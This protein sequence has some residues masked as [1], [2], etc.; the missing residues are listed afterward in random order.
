MRSASLVIALLSALA[1]IT[2]AACSEQPPT[3][4]PD[5]PATV[6]SAIEQS[7][8]TTT[9][10]YTPVPTVT[11]TFQQW[12]SHELSR[13]SCENPQNIVRY[14]NPNTTPP[15][16]ADLYCEALAQPTATPTPH[17]TRIPT[18]TPTF[19][20][21]LRQEMSAL[22][23]KNPGDKLTWENAKRTQP[24]S[25]DFWC[26]S[27]TPT[28]QPTAT[29][30]FNQWLRQEMSALECESPGDKLTW[31][32]AK[33]T[34]PYS[35]DF[36]CV[37]PTPTPRPTSTPTFSQ[38]LQQEM[39]TLKC[40]DPRDKLTWENARRTQPYG[41]DFRCVSP[42]PTLRPTPTWQEWLSQERSRL[43]CREYPS[44]TLKYRNAKTTPPYSADFYCAPPLTSTPPP[45]PTMSQMIQWD[46][47][48]RVYYDQ[49]ARNGGRFEITNV[50]SAGNGGWTWQYFCHL[51]ASQS[52]QQS[53]LGNQSEQA[54]LECGI[55]IGMALFTSD[56]MELL[57]CLNLLE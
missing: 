57:R 48:T 31:E 41:A 16:F 26:V 56:W 37:S 51:P 36:W 7:L 22:E 10:A 28:P 53:I 44:S 13:A 33:R 55:S 46:R 52:Q 54:L 47:N 40:D 19:N 30:T 27:P 20:Q 45:T 42:M 3:S 15:Y 5:I 39:S 9:L 4:T 43:S 49:C 2:I 35:A 23:C 8:P 25:A 18:A 50:Q 38:W 24:Y 11:Q 14:R 32:N 29:P 21:W 1:F 6:Q 12:L 34:Q 17:L